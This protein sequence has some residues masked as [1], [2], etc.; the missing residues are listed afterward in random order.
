LGIALAAQTVAFLY[1]CALGAALGLLY[2][3]FRITRIAFPTGKVGVFLEDLLF[4]FLCAAATFFYLMGAVQ[5]QVRFFLLLGELLGAVL[6]Y[7][8]LGQLVMKI[9]RALID[10][11]KRML[12]FLYR[13][14][15][16]PIWR[17]F[18]AIV[19]LLLLPVRFLGIK[20][21]KTATIIKFHLKVRRIVLY[22]QV[23][24]YKKRGKKKI[25]EEQEDYG[26][27]A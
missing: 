16:L 26:T 7:F 12:L 4:F 22:N 27:E 5:G 6:Y 8:T 20:V 24:R 25:A 9:S 15:V 13:Y 11:I 2:D 23:A 17:F 18:Y 3:V 19:R 21:K 14:L 1:A 10:G